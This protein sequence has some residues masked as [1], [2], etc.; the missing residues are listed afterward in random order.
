MEEQ[1]GQV[2][3]TVCQ[4]NFVS[5]TEPMIARISVLV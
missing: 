3:C 5:F 1:L 2:I 4:D